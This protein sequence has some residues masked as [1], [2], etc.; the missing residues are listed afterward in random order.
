MKKKFT[1][2]LSAIL[3]AAC[4][5]YALTE[6]TGD[7]SSSAVTSDPDESRA[8]Q[9]AAEDPAD[10]ASPDEEKE[11]GHDAA[12]EAGGDK[13][14][15]AEEAEGGEEEQGDSGGGSGNGGAGYDESA[16]A[17]IAEPESITVLVNKLNRLPLDYRPDD[18]VYPEVPFIFQEK[19]EKRM[20]R[21]VAAEALERMFAAAEEDGIL[22]AGVSGFRSGST[23]KSLFEYY[24]SRDG[25]EKASRYSARPG[26]SEHQTG[27]AMDVSG[28]S[29]KCA[30][31][32][33]FADTAE[34]AWLAEH[35]HEHGFIIRYPKGKE[36]ITGY[37]YEPWHLRY[38]GPEI[39]EEIWKRGITL[40]EYFGAVPASADAADSGSDSSL[41]ADDSQPS[42]EPAPEAESKPE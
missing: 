38:V 29:G 11:N 22:L 5:I 14:E 8:P 15:A 1:M 37:K 33:C 41:D 32:D 19:V 2:I 25:E 39:A 9:A 21:K 24:V 35:A 36:E 10:G 20:M 3:L 34:A 17:V 28:I 23:Q 12:S 13:Q 26:H 6:L 4:L 7:R 40:E 42:P 27:L 18:L 30:A 31:T 16:V